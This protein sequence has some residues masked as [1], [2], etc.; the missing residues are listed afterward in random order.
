[1]DPF[2]LRLLFGGLASKYR[3]PIAISFSLL[4]H[5]LL[6]SF[7]FPRHPPGLA[8]HG[9]SG[10]TMGGIESFDISLVRVQQSVLALQPKSQTTED[11]ETLSK[12]APRTTVEPLSLATEKVAAV[13]PVVEMPPSTV[14]DTTPNVMPGAVATGVGDQNNKVSDLWRAI[15]PCW[16]RI[17]DK[18]AVPVSLEISFSPLGNVAKPP[19]LLGAPST[20]L[21]DQLQRSQAQAIEALSECG[22]YLMAYGQDHVQVA[23]PG[24]GS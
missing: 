12:L 21:S 22:P 7:L 13:Q 18:D 17:A 2:K 16:N 10:D 15:A 4:L 8:S 24:K 5:L 3:L 19:I 14:A 23:F 11:I 6:F 20:G 1:M 9:I